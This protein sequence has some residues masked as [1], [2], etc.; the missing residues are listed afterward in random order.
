MGAASASTDSGGDDMRKAGG[1][2]FDFTA[3]AGEERGTA[4]DLAYTLVGPAGARGRPTTAD[5]DLVSDVE[6][7]EVGVQ[8]QSAADDAASS[9]GQSMGF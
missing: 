7:D 9:L 5:M 1:D 3:Q 8:Y 6:I 4:G 2:A